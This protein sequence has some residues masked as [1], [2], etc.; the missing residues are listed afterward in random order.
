MS[1]LD[2]T[3]TSQG[4]EENRVKTNGQVFTPDSI[5]NEM[6]DDTDRKLADNL[7]VTEISDIDYIEYTVLEPT[8][9][10]GNFLV[11]ILD[12]KLERVNNFSNKEQ[13]IMLLKAIS[14]IYAIE[15]TAENVV[16]TKLRMMEVIENGSTDIFELGYKQKQGFRTKGFKISEDIKKSIHYILDRNII[17]GN[18]LTA[19]KQLIWKSNYVDNVWILDKN[20]A[21]IADALFRA[22]HTDEHIVLTQYDF[23]EDKVAIRERTYKNMSE[24]VES[25]SNASRY[26]DYNK[27]Y[28]LDTPK[29]YSSNNDDLMDDFDF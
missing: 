7:G 2:G 21:L 23:S 13:E 4:A 12:R 18:T 26:V 5:V 29:I 9:G 16:A 28:E 3:S 1:N 15:L 10:N 24:E 14:S 19:K 8:C 25:Y 20:K 11:R 6:L 27:I 22:E 17:C